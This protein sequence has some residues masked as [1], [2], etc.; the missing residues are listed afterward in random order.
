MSMVQLQEA[1]LPWLASPSLGPWDKQVTVG[2]ARGVTL[3]RRGFFLVQLWSCEPCGRIAEHAH[4]NVDGYAAAVAGDVL[5]TIGGTVVR[6]EDCTPARF[7]GAEIFLV[8][9]PA[10]T[11]HAARIGRSGGAFL[12]LTWWRDRAP[13]SVHLD[14]LGRALDINHALELGR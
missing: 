7:A 3:H 9:V 2:C 5:F 8:P 14:W 11:L 12:S 6:K 1:A 13:S 4:P 10:S